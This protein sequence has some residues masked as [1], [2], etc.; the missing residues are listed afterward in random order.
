M[1]KE[2]DMELNIMDWL[3]PEC[4]LELHKHLIEIICPVSDVDEPDASEKICLKCKW[5][6]G[7]SGYSQ[8]CAYALHG[9]ETLHIRDG[10]PR[11]KCLLEDAPEPVMSNLLENMEDINPDFSKAVD[12]HFWELL[13]DA[14][15][16]ADIATSHKSTKTDSL[17]GE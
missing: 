11:G 17:K 16:P 4:G 1:V 8:V 3:C 9:G 2:S 10:K 14:P 13:A 7:I 12:R 15:E 5:N 6:D